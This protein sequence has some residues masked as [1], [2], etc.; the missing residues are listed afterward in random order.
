MNLRGPLSVRRI[1][2]GLC[3]RSVQ[4]QKPL[5]GLEAALQRLE[6]LK[7]LCPTQTLPPPLEL[8]GRVIV[9]EATHVAVAPPRLASGHLDMGGLG[10]APY[11]SIVLPQPVL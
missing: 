11:L 7:I 9:G 3:R 6:A 8:E 5:E 10:P 4:G 2:D 1:G